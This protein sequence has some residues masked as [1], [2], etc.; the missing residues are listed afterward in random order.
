MKAGDLEDSEGYNRSLQT[1]KERMGLFLM[2][3]ELKKKKN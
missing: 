2:S 1:F 3:P